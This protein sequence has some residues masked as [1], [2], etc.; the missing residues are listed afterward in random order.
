MFPGQRTPDP[1]W[2]DPES[3]R[4][5]GILGRDASTGLVDVRVLRTCVFIGRSRENFQTTAT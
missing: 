5:A 3:R 2:R 1:A 4:R